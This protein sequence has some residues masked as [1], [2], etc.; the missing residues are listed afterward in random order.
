MSLRDPARVSRFEKHGDLIDGDLLES[1][2]AGDELALERLYQRYFR[3]LIGFAVRVTGRTDVAEEVASDT[4]MAVWCGAKGYEGRSRPSTWIFGIAYRIALKARKR[5][6]RTVEEIEVDLAA[7]LPDPE[8]GK[9]IE[10]LFL[11]RQLARAMRHLSPEHRAVIQLTYY[12]G[13]SYPE[14]SEILACPVGTVK[15]RMSHARSRLTHFLVNPQ[16]TS[17][18]E[19]TNA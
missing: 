6:E 3:K 14:I 19:E 1:I 13:Y 12:Y 16:S 15:S 2:S 7:E 18:T 5:L 8:G 10:N 4:V 9:A 17:D 11:R